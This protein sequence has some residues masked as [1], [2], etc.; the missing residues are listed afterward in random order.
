MLWSRAADGNGIVESYVADVLVAAVAFAL[1][2]AFMTARRPGLSIGWVATAIGVSEGAGLLAYGYATWALSRGAVGGPLTSWVALWLWLPGF[3][4]AGVV[5]PLLFPTGSL[6]SR[7]WRWLLWGAAVCAFLL[8]VP[9]AAATWTSRG[10]AL[11]ADELVVPPGW[12]RSLLDLQDAA[13]IALPI[14]AAA[15]LVCVGIRF[16]R[17]NETTRLQIGVVVAAMAAS[18]VLTT[19]GD[20]ALG[21]SGTWVGLL[22]VPLPVVGIGVA[23]LR[24]GLWDLD[25]VLNRT[26]VFV[27]LS[28]CIAV[29]YAVAVTALVRLLPDDRIPLPSLLSAAAVAALFHPL[30]VRLQRGVD[31]LLYGRRGDPYAVLAGVIRPLEREAEPGAALNGALA[32][33]AEGLKLPGVRVDVVD[34][35]GVLRT[36]AAV[37]SSSEG[38]WVSVPLRYGGDEVGELQCALRQGSDGFSHRERQ[39]LEDLANH[40]AVTAKAVQLTGEVYRSR[41]DIV[42]AREEERRLLRRELHDRLAAPLTGIAFGID[43]A[44]RMQ[45]KDPQAAEQLQA[46]LITQTQ[47]SI[48]VV[49]DIIGQLR[50]A[51]ID[52][53]GLVEA[54]R[55]RARTL[56]EPAGVEVEIVADQ[57]PDSVNAAVESAAYSIASEALTNIV[58][59]ARARRCSMELRL[60]NGALTLAVADDG[61]GFTGRRAG[62][63]GVQ[64]MTDRAAELG[65]TAD[66]RPASGGGTVVT[67]VLP[68]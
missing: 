19:I 2:G 20:L 65:G 31:R 16:W 10:P 27:G 24:R 51:V 33:I 66:V 3:V 14:I 32:T 49:R 8:V 22:A 5:L 15:A 62:G 45:S 39:L 4:L 56:L 40:V 6:L 37:G 44:R 36:A 47:E 53:R 11:L 48:E 61:R 34:V 67:V 7:R 12:R 25:A 50:P 63:L 21:D 64:T 55:E 52:D 23:V 29:V 13:W 43:A 59:H 38:P 60:A 58:K 57:L 18:F 35:E 54:L 46:A 28:V 41:A 30:Q 9:V 1:L 26:L 68:L 42:L 17:G